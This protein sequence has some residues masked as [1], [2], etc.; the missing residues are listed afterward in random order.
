MSTVPCG[1]GVG[2]LMTI[3]FWLRTRR[4]ISRPNSSLTTE[5]TVRASASFSVTAARP[6][7][8]TRRRSRVRPSIHSRSGENVL[9]TV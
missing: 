7:D 2:R 1:T 4:N 5:F 9:S 8:C 6:N 3:E